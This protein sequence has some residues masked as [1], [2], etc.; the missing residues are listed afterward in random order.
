MYWM[1]FGPF[2]VMK[3]SH[4]FHI[5]MEDNRSP[6]FA[7]WVKYDMNGIQ[8]S[9]RPISCSNTFGFLDISF[10]F[11]GLLNGLEN[12]QTW[13]RLSGY[14]SDRWWTQT[15]VSR[16]ALPPVRCFL[17]LATSPMVAFSWFASNW[18]QYASSTVASAIIH[19]TPAWWRSWGAQAWHAWWWEPWWPHH[20]DTPRI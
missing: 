9:R 17:H 12:M 11:R 18:H 13:I 15:V 7:H 4:L 2:G 16:K 8:R 19:Y 20:L 5:D 3:L 6:Q 1:H 10:S 14:S